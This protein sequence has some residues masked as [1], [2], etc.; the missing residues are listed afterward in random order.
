MYVIGMPFIIGSMSHTYTLY[1]YRSSDSH[2]DPGDH[3][4][5]FTA[6]GT[7]A[8]EAGLRPWTSCSI[9]PLT[10]R[11]AQR[12]CPARPWTTG[13]INPQTTRPAYSAL[14][15]PAAKDVARKCVCETTIEWRTDQHSGVLTKIVAYRLVC[16]T[17]WSRIDLIP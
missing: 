5:P 7:R 17:V 4:D 9:N 2:I 16:E 1:I 3:G 15:P 14:A 11:P 12:P 8:R 6:P 13:S 10:T